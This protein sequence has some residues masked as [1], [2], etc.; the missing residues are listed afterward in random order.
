MRLSKARATA[1]R[2][3]AARI[4][5]QSDGV[6]D[7]NQLP[8]ILLAGNADVNEQ[9]VNLGRLGVLFLLHQVRSDVTHHA[10][11]GAVAG[12]NHHPLGFGD[13]GVH[14]PHLSD[15]DEPLVCDVIDGHGNLVRVAREHEA[16]GTALVE[17]GH[18]V[19]ESVG[20]GFLGEGVDVVEPDPLAADFMADGAG[21]VFTRVLRTAAM[22]LRMGQLK[23]TAG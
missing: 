14:A 12:M 19:A 8:R 10:F 3:A 2:S 11:D 18:T 16:G 13:G 1:G 23:K 21:G 20:Q 4:R 5:R 17:H 9:V 6:A 22:R 7:V 15:M